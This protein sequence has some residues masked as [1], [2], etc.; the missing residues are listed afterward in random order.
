[1]KE[2]KQ[3]DLIVRL[4]EKAVDGGIRPR[5][6]S[7]GAIETAVRIHPGETGNGMT[8]KG[9]EEARDDD[10]ARVGPDALAPGV[11]YKSIGW[12]VALHR[13][14]AW[15]IRRIE[16]PI[17]I[18]PGDAGAGHTHSRSSYDEEKLAHDDDFA[19]RLQ[20]QLIDAP[21]ESRS[22]S[23]VIG[24]IKRDSATGV[25]TGVERAVTVE[26]R[27]GGRPAHPVHRM[28]KIRDEALAIWLENHIGD[29]HIGTHAGIQR[30]V[31]R[32]VRIQTRNVMARD[33]V[34]FG[35]LPRDE[36]FPV[37]LQRR[38]LDQPVRKSPGG[39]ERRVECAIGLDQAEWPLGDWIARRAGGVPD[40]CQSWNGGCESPGQEAH[41]GN[42]RQGSYSFHRSAGVCLLKKNAAREAEV[43]E[44]ANRPS[45]SCG[46]WVCCA[47]LETK[48]GMDGRR[49]LFMSQAF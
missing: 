30:E 10:L 45:H 23:A 48:W 37:G 32:P 5:A 44:A 17:A 29:A 12:V 28:K 25:E 26:P 20:D 22:A 3:D 7:E 43:R 8:V 38:G 40:R 21:R 46:E 2:S 41:G 35:E 16:S 31:E 6:G 15:S 4:N 13:A 14:G 18:E 24:P 27:H 36:Q 49:P 11:K 34:D 42:P 39:V 33:A 1:M 19:V 47:R 9:V